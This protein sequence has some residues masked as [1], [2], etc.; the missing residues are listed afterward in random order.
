MFHFVQLQAACC[1]AIKF[2]RLM[3]FTLHLGCLDD[4]LECSLEP[5]ML[6]LHNSPILKVLRIDYVCDFINVPLKQVS[7]LIDYVI[8]FLLVAF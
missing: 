4:D 5:L 3:K 8:T 2:P 1:S 6:F 7:V